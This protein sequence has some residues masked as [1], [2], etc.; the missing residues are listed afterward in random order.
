ME[1][2][3]YSILT[4]VPLKSTSIFSVR[5]HNPGVQVPERLRVSRRGDGGGHRG[6][7]PSPPP[8]SGAGTWP[9][10]V[11]HGAVS[12]GDYIALVW[13]YNGLVQNIIECNILIVEFW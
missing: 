7:R 6:G 13:V 4:L 8:P 12:I 3:R 9:L 1:T 11:T 5:G 2:F 10:L